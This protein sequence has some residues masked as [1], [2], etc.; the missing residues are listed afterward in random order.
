MIYDLIPEATISSPQLISKTS[1]KHKC[2]GEFEAS[3]HVYYMIYRYC[4]E[5]FNGPSTS[6]PT[7]LMQKMS[8]LSWDDLEPCKR[9]G[10]NYHQMVHQSGNHQLRWVVV[11]Y[12]FLRRFFKDIPGGGLLRSCW[13]FHVVLA[14]T[15]CASPDF[16]GFLLPWSGPI[17]T[18]PPH[19]PGPSERWTSH[20]SSVVTGASVWI[21]RRW[22]NPKTK[23]VS[24]VG[25]RIGRA[26]QGCLFSYCCFSPKR[27]FSFS[28]EK[29]CV[30][31]FSFISKT[32]WAHLEIPSVF[33]HIS[34]QILHGFPPRGVDRVWDEVS[35]SE[36]WELPRPELWWTRWCQIIPP[37]FTQF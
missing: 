8:W 12:H 7:K 35:W 22:G 10:I 3:C 15:Y 30:F 2:L 4:I 9:I 37:F 34:P 36:W 5:Y 21:V 26:G 23:P 24:S 28:K 31:C 29:H 27:P 17:P 16:Y 6:Q 11:N 19:M 33:Q 14:S 32:T 25:T 18:H 20:C 1:F 13:R